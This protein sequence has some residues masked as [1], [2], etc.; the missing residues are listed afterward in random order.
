[1]YKI[2]LE[3]Y[4]DFPTGRIFLTDSY[5]VNSNP[6]ATEKIEVKE[7][8]V[9]DAVGQC[10]NKFDVEIGMFVSPKVFMKCNGDCYPCEVFNLHEHVFLGNYFELGMTK[11]LENLN[12]NKYVR[13]IRKYGTVSFRD[14][15]P[16]N[17]LKE[18]FCETECYG[19]EF[20]IKFCE[21]NNLIR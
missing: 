9:Y 4:G 6:E 19:C 12:T 15:I 17:I 16:T 13:F 14:V 7:I 18:N 8:S 5:Y 3:K 21:N 11:V 10:E 2:Y 1:L 20:C